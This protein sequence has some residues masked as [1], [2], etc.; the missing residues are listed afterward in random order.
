MGQKG[1]RHTD[2]GTAAGN[3]IQHRDLA[4]EF[5]RIVERGQYG[6]SHQARVLRALRRGRQKHN[7]VRAVT[8]V[9]VK[10]MLDRADMG[11]AQRVAQ[12]DGAQRFVPVIPSRFF[13]FG[14]IGEKTDSEFNRARPVY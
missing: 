3:R 8:A 14:H 10:V 4:R 13:G 7:R 12:I 11:V 1:A 5:E 9:S 6:T 2:I